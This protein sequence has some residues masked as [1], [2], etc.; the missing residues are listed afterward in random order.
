[1]FYSMIANILK[2]QIL[3]KPGLESS[4]IPPDV[5]APAEKISHWGKTPKLVYFYL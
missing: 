1:M 4:V 2:R 5:S 3:L